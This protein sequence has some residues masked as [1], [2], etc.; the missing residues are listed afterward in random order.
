MIAI[1]YFFFN[2][3]FIT[4]LLYL[5]YIFLYVIA[6]TKKAR[7]QTGCINEGSDV[8]DQTLFP[9]ASC[10][11]LVNSDTKC[12]FCDQPM[13]VFCSAV[14]L[15]DGVGD[16]ICK[17][18]SSKP[19]ARI[20]EQEQPATIEEQEHGL[21]KEDEQ[22]LPVGDDEVPDWNLLKKVQNAKLRKQQSSGTGTAVG[23]PTQKRSREK[24]TLICLSCIVVIF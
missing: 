12:T 18:C 7:K 24:G 8:P 22:P 4:S 1:F 20:E 23:K 11:E 5:F 16:A 21:E 6:A 14:E 3:L 19:P 2:F 13:H 9:C 17:L 10:T 15:V